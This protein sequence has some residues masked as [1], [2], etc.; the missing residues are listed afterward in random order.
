MTIDGNELVKVMLTGLATGKTDGS[1]V[2][3]SPG[4]SWEMH[5]RREPG[6]LS[7][8]V[9]TW[10]LLSGEVRG[11]AWTGDFGIEIRMTMKTAK[12]RAKARARALVLFMVYSSFL[13]CLGILIQLWLPGG[14]AR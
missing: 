5:S 3:A 9:V 14:I 12:G 10:Q 13:T 2:M 11:D 4:V 6:P 8:D 7:A 1:K